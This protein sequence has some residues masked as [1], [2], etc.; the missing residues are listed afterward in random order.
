MRLIDLVTREAI[1]PELQAEDRDAAVAELLAASVNARRVDAEAESEI[2]EAIRERERLGSTGFGKGVAV[3]HA[4][5]AKVREM[6]AAVGLSKAG[7]DFQS[8][9][10]RPVNVVVL[11]ISPADRSREHLDAMQTIFKVLQQDLVR[12]DLRDATGREAVLDV[13]RQADG[14]IT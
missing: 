11:L 5:H 6:T 7:I 14:A 10:G 3:P 4:K 2:L 12:R 9:D 1:V 8:L 13:L